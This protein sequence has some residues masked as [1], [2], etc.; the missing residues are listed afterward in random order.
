MNLLERLKEI[1]GGGADHA[2]EMII[3]KGSLKP[4]DDSP[5]A[6]EIFDPES[7]PSLNMI[8]Q[9]PTVLTLYRDRCMV[10]CFIRSKP[11][12]AETRIQQHQLRRCQSQDP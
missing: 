11:S 4:S 12:Y 2:V 5:F 1:P 9:S 6:N 3:R 10:Q 7:T 8:L